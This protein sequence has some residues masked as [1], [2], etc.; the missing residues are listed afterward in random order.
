VLP[1]DSRAR[2]ATA[3]AGPVRHPAP[4]GGPHACGRPDGAGGPPS[5]RMP[6]GL[7]FTKAR[8]AV[9][10]D[11]GERAH[12]GPLRLGAACRMF[13]VAAAGEP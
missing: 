12:L 4:A 8:A 9:R 3:A 10:W 1:P 6:F 2:S 13:R 5:F 7:Y 11:R